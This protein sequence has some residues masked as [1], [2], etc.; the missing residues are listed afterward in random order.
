MGVP[1]NWWL[2]NILRLG[3][4]IDALTK[5]ESLFVCI[6]S[7]RAERFGCSSTMVL[8]WWFRQEFP[9]SPTRVQKGRSPGMKYIRNVFCVPFKSY[10][11]KTFVRVDVFNMAI[12]EAPSTC[13][14]HLLFA[15]GSQS[16]ESFLKDN[17]NGAEWLVSHSWWTECCNRRRVE[18]KVARE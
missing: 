10:V 9:A 18:D 15:C 6:C 12:S 5:T 17:G 13:C 16:E 11:L 14:S 8:S 1:G 2:I 3:M 4:W 7:W